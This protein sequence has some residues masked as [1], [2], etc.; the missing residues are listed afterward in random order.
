M[1]GKAFAERLLRLLKST[2]DEIRNAQAAQT[3][4]A[5][6][7]RRP[8]DAG[9][10]VGAK[11]FLGSKDLPITYANTDPNRRKLV[12]RFIGPYTIVRMVGPNAVELDL[13]RDMKIHDVIN[14][15][16]LKLDCSSTD[17]ILKPPP[18]P[19]RT[20]KAG[21]T[22]YAV[23][24]ILSHLPDA[25]NTWQYRVKWEGWDDNDSTWE[26]ESALKN[27]KQAVDDYWNSIGG[28]PKTAVKKI[29]RMRRTTRQR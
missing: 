3:A 18:P 21:Q 5:N 24:K 13:P 23:E 20:S 7:A 1:R 17:R 8:V 6:R 25:K 26:P 15:S 12:H 10:K 4:Q 11:V 19:I 22:T 28:R 9:I 14:V 29:R 27:A 2:Q 16:R